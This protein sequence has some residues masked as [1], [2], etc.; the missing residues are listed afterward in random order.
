MKMHK[1]IGHGITRKH[2]TDQLGSTHWRSGDKCREIDSMNLPS[3]N[4]EMRC[5]KSAGWSG[6]GSLAFDFVCVLPCASVLLTLVFYGDTK[7]TREKQSRREREAEGH[8]KAA[9]DCP[10]PGQGRRPRAAAPTA[11]R[12]P[13][14]AAGSARA[15]GGDRRRSAHY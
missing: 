4:K 10:A 11:R 9:V 2:T 7:A 14:R 8:C 5:A 12:L 15:P 6:K 3:F 1:S 13:S